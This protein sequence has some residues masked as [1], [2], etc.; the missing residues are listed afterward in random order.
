VGI[1]LLILETKEGK[2]NL[3]FQIIII[4]FVN[5][6]SNIIAIITFGKKYNF[7]EN[8]IKQRNDVVRQ[9]SGGGFLV[10]DYEEE[11]HRING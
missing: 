5:Y 4:A 3:A 10:T 8:Q 2:V 1:P 6:L 11:G 7:Q 9:H